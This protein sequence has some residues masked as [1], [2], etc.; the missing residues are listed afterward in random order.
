MSKIPLRIIPRL[1][2]KGKNLIKGINL[3]GL[4]VVGDPNDFAKKYYEQGADELIF[5]DNVASLYGRN[6]LYNVIHEA[7]KNVFIPI[8]VGGGIRSIKDANKVLRAGADKIA[9][10]TAAVKNPNIISQ[11]SKIFG[12]QCIVVSI[13]AKK[14]DNNQW[15]VYTLNG[16]E[17]TGINLIDW[18]KKIIDCGAGEIL[19]TSVD[20]DGTKEGFDLDLIKLSSKL[21]NIPLIVCGGCGSLKDIINLKKKKFNIDGIGLGTVLHYE[22]IKIND[23][24]KV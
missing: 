13:E 5:M 18:I 6:N 24:K 7:T 17:R 11:L 15:E 12:S 3:E 23:A 14:V 1:D 9:I 2:I 4:R 10:N 19:L 8:T 16:R 20:K 22:K 21:C